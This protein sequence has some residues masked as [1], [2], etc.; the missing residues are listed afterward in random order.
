MSDRE[1][2]ESSLAGD[3]EAIDRL[4][5]R[6]RC[7]PRLIVSRNSRSARR[8]TQSELD[9]VV[10]E[11]LMAVW[12]KLRTY[13]G[14]ARIESWA[15]RFAY[16]EY[17]S[18]LRGRSRDRLRRESALPAEPSVHPRLPAALEHEEL[19]LALGR[20]PE[21]HHDILYLK[22]LEGLSME[23]VAARLDIPLNTVKSRLHRG[24]QRMRAMLARP[25]AER[26]EKQE[27][28]R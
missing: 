13:D 3:Q 20:L 22:Y 23:Q 10:Q 24:L 8:L 2:V 17:L 27:G 28:R 1:L 11:A 14:S 4:L 21:R 15:M 9:D 16:L 6:L 26:A 25:R 5:L 12:R 18:T 19:H 7:V